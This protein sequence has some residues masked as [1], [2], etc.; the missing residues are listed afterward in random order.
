MVFVR[1]AYQAAVLPGTAIFLRFGLATL[2]LILFLRLSG[3]WV[4][5]PASRVGAIFMLGFFGF[6]VMGIT[7]FVALSLMPAWLVALMTAMYPLLTNLGSWLFLKEQPGGWQVAALLAVLL[8]GALLFI[9]PFEEPVAWLGI[10][11]MGLNIITVAAYQLVG[12]HWTRGVPPLMSAVWTIIGAAVSTFFYALWVN[13]LTFAF[14]PAGWFWA[15]CFAV[16]STAFAIIAQ[17]WGIGLIGAARVAILGSFEPLAAVVLAVLVL[18]ETLAP[19]QL[20]GGLF[21][22][23][24]MFLVQ[25]RPTYSAAPT[26]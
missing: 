20:V 5:L 25:Y 12:Q 26:S 24:G 17:W 4:S 15:F 23:A 21:I 6:S 13:E 11:L 22:L 19:L 14:A 7:F 9:Q 8:G 2:V 16:V 10:L 18:D 1:Y 3:R